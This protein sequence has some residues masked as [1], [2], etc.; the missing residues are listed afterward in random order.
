MKVYSLKTKKGAPRHLQALQGNYWFWLRGYEIVSFEHQQLTDGELDHD[1]ISD[2]EHTLVYASVAVVREALIRA[3]R[4]APPNIDF[5]QELIAFIGR[6]IAETTM[7]EVRQ[8]EKS[9]PDRLPVHVKPR[10]HQKLFT[11]KV[12]GAFRDLISLSY[13]RDDEPVIVQEVVDFASEWRASVLRGQIVNVSHYKGAPLL[14]PDIAT[15][16][17][18]IGHFSSAPIAYAVDWGVTQ[19]GRTVLVEVNDGFALGNYGVPGSLYTALIEC[20]WRQLMGL[21]DNGVGLSL[22]R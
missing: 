14:F 11:G 19:D 7:S 13:V 15:M 4:P 22:S 21:S 1:L 8:W 3:G 16:T 20:R 17:S 2:P 18:A 10:D 12:V 5:P 6:R 9:N